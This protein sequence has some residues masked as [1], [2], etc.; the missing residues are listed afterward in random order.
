VQITLQASEDSVPIA[1][2]LIALDQS[3]DLALVAV[4]NPRV[5]PLA[6]FPALFQNPPIASDMDCSGSIMVRA[7]GFSSSPDPKK[8]ERKSTKYDSASCDFY[9]KTY[10]IGGM[11]YNIALYRANTAF[12][13]GFSG[14]PVLDPDHRLVGIV[15][16]AVPALAGE[17]KDVFFVP[18]SIIKTFLLRYR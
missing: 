4:R 14:G 10:L 2:S 3:S 9:P 1:A 13:P 8:L 16:G 6:N 7:I 5:M 15:S 17:P 18:L 11:K 12:Q